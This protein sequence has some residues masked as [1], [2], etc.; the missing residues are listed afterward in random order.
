[1]PE[2]KQTKYV[3]SDRVLASATQ[4]TPK[5]ALLTIDAGLI[6]K[7]EYIERGGLSIHALGHAEFT[8]LGDLLVTPAF[9]NG[10]THLAMNAFRGV[11][12]DAM[13][14]NIVEELYYH[15]EHSLTRAEVTAFTRMGAYDCLLAGVGL[16]WDH[17][18]HGQGVADALAEVGLTGVVAPTLQDLA[19]PGVKWLDQQLEA[20]QLIHQGAHYKNAGV[21]AALGPHATDTVSD[22]LWQRVG[23][24][25]ADYDIPIHAHV[26]QSKDEFERCYNRNKV[27]TLTYLNQLGVLDSGPGF[28]MVH[29]QYIRPA[30]LT[31]LDGNRHVLGHCP[32][33]QVQFCFPAPIELWHNAGVGVLLGTDSSACNDTMNVQQELRLVAEGDSYVVTNQAKLTEATFA[34]DDCSAALEALRQQHREAR[35]QIQSTDEL[36]KMAWSNGNCLHPEVQTGILAAGHLA[37]LAVWDLEHPALWPANDVKRTIT[38]CD[39]APALA[40]M[41]TNGIWRGERGR[42]AESLLQTEAFQRA[43]NEAKLRLKEL[44]DRLGLKGPL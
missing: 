1:M 14:G 39:T 41:M 2:L 9:V 16:V 3:Y 11:G 21:F 38:F 33:S 37:N 24:L 36:L 7:I 35:S 19:G 10:H 32:Y 20:T 4:R 18:Y 43:K 12:L 15:L 13:D 25:S 34:Q 29:G 44:R 27:G 8:D 40:W 17:Y 28:L 6:S 31:L 23:Q 22:T 26:A 5:P 30:E 42:Y